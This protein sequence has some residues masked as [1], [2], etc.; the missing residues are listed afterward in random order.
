LVLKMR[1]PWPPAARKFSVRLVV[2]RAEGLLPPAADADVEAK[3]AVEVTWKGPK[4]RWKGIRVCRNRTRLEPAAAADAASSSSAAAVVEWEEE[5]EDV[6]T[7]TATSHR[8]AAAAFQPWDLSFSVLN[9][10]TLLSA[11]VQF[12]SCSCEKK[13]TNSHVRDVISSPIVGLLFDDFLPALPADFES[14]GSLD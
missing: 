10:S 3:V 9:V 7:L 8:K 11:Y 6:V 4:A 2:R 1:W 13:K 12:F 5:F 14:I